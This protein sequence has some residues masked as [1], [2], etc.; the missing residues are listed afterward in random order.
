MPSRTVVPS[1]RLNDLERSIVAG[2][3]AAEDGRWMQAEEVVRRLDAGETQREVAASWLN[4]RTGQPY[5]PGHVNA[6]AKV[7]RRFGVRSSERPRWT[8]AYETARSGSEEIV[9]P[10]DRQRGEREA[11]PPT[12]VESAERLTQRLIE[13]APEEVREAVEQGLRAH[14]HGQPVTRRERR[15]READ[16]ADAMEPVV[17]ALHR[18]FAQMDVVLAL[19][20]VTETLRE[21]I[22]E[23]SLNADAMRAIDE[24]WEEATAEIEVA[25]AFVGA[26]ERR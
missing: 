20:S 5:R 3:D 6:V 7:W 2:E 23:R 9:A 26:E 13:D 25:R 1:N 12:T 18:P 8:D 21:M 19:R 16:A 11:Q 17:A 10:F 15:E 22:A 24:A 14:R 4:L